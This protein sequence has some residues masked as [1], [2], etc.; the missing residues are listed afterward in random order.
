M[1]LTASIRFADQQW[2][3]LGTGVPRWFYMAMILRKRHAAFASIDNP[4]AVVVSCFARGKGR[5]GHS[6]HRRAR[7]VWVAVGSR[8][9]PNRL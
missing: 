5:G 9:S 2:L 7:P 6:I 1:R 4:L 8:E 3:R